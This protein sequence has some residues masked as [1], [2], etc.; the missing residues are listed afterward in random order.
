MFSISFHFQKLVHENTL[1]CLR[2]VS[3]E[4]SGLLKNTPASFLLFLS[5]LELHCKRHYRNLATNLV[6]NMTWTRREN[7]AGATPTCGR[8]RRRTALAYKGNIVQPHKCLFYFK[9][10]KTS[11]SM[12]SN[13]R[14]S[15]VWYRCMSVTLQLW[16]NSKILSRVAR[17][18]DITTIRFTLYF[19]EKH[20][21][22]AISR[23]QPKL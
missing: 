2:H 6:Y 22:V 8:R 10:T 17:I 14:K 13:K 7:G 1:V 3:M 19:S 9:W 11:F 20:L 16:P 12:L 5:M 23:T 15:T 4:Y 21:L 18:A